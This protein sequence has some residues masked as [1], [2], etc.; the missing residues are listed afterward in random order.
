MANLARTRPRVDVKTAGLS[1]WALPVVPL[2]AI[3]D[4]VQGRPKRVWLLLKVTPR[5][6]AVQSW[7]GRRLAV[8][9]E[10]IRD[11]YDLSSLQV[12]V[13]DG[14]DAKLRVDSVWRVASKDWRTPDSEAQDRADRSVV[15]MRDVARLKKQALRLARVTGVQ[16]SIAVYKGP[17]PSQADFTLRGTMAALVLH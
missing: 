12:D 7:G 2:L 8:G 4:M 6:R 15:L 9:C 14:D 11:R 17:G 3:E 13:V 16:M 5:L 10:E 1:W